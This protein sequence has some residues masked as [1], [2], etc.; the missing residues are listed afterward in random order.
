MNPFLDNT[1][2]TL[3]SNKKIVRKENKSYLEVNILH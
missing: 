1:H 3:N 2:F